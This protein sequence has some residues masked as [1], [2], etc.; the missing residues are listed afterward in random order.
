MNVTFCI[1]GAHLVD[2]VGDGYVLTPDQ[3][4]RWMRRRTDAIG[5]G[6]CGRRYTI[7]DLR[8]MVQPPP[9]ILAR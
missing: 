9:S 7:E 4:R 3:Q 8:S 5:C 1:C 2:E 6:A